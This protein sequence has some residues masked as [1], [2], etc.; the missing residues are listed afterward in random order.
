VD[1][2]SGLFPGGLM[3]DDLILNE[4]ITPR[5]TFAVASDPW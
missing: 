5:F 2:A 1:R 3:N 4:K